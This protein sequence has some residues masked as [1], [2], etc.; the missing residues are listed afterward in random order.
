MRACV[1]VCVCVS[2][3]VCVCGAGGGTEKLGYQPR[4]SGAEEKETLNINDVGKYGDVL[5]MLGRPRRPPSHMALWYL[6]VWI[7]CPT[8]GLCIQ[9]TCLNILIEITKG[10]PNHLNRCGC[11]LWTIRADSFCIYS[12]VLVYI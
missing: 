8:V 5:A 2:L 10:N 9:N 4:H 11:S 1:C 7:Y 12:I 3:C 6:A